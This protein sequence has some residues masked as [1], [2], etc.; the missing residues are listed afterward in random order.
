LTCKQR[1]S[2]FLIKNAPP[3]MNTVRLFNGYVAGLMTMFLFSLCYFVIRYYEAYTEVFKRVE[4]KI[5]KVGDAMPEFTEILG[6]GLHNFLLYCILLL[7]VVVWNYLYYY[8]D[9]KSIYLMKRL[10]NRMELHR[11]AW[12]LPV[13]GILVTLVVAFLLL[14]CCYGIYN[15][16]TPGEYIVPGQ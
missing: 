2:N 8:Q 5:I 12:M 9:S 16:V 6:N 1:L 15:I 4:D 7:A 14:V 13:L 10:P 3:G 11:R